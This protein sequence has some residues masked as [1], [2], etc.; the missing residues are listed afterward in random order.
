MCDPGVQSGSRRPSGSVRVKVTTPSATTD[1]PVMCA[2]TA[3]P[4]TGGVEIVTG[5]SCL[6]RKCCRDG[7]RRHHRLLNG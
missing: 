7:E 2:E 5:L 4:V 3:L 6:F 1:F